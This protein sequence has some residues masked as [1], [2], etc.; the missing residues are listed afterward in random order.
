MAIKEK[1][2]TNRLILRQFTKD[3]IQAI[4]NIY[5]DE[6]ANTY[7]PWY[8]LKSLK[9]AE[10]L[11]YE[12]YE[13]EYNNNNPYKYAVCLKEDN[14]PIGY[15]H[16]SNDDSYDLGYGLRKKFWHNKIMTEATKAFVENLKNHSIPY[17]TATH[18]INNQRS[19]NVMKNIGMT[20]CYTYKEQWQPKNILVTFRMYQLNLDGEKERIYKG[21]WNKYSQHF[22]EKDI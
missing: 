15:I 17:I 13:N 1:I 2:Y 7:L 14:I 8:P 3:D 12:K 9:E 21:Y 11:F 10:N 19:G 22:I 20:Y 5:K 6:E 18:D 4:F 16:L